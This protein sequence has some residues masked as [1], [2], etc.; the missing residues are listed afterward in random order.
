VQK[1]GFEKYLPTGEGLLAFGNMEEA[2]DGIE[3]INADY[4][5]HSRRASEIALEFF[6]AKV[7][8]PQLLRDAR[9]D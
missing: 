3:K 8:L 1:T 6:D 7:G 2:L 4:E 9:V 5:K